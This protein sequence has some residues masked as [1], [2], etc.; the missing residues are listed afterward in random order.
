MHNLI[1]ALIEYAVV[2]YADSRCRIARGRRIASGLRD[3]QRRRLYAEH[4]RFDEH[5]MS[6]A[7]DNWAM[8]GEDRICICQMASEILLRFTEFCV[9]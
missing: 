5:M 4:Q 2:C 1:R 3:S 8:D 7:R 9:F 6:Y